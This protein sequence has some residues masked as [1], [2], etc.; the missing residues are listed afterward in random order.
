MLGSERITFYDFRLFHQLLGIRHLASVEGSNSVEFQTRCE[1]NKPYHDLTLFLGLSTDYLKSANSDLNHLIWLDYDFGYGGICHNDLATILPRFKA[2]TIVIITIDFERPDRRSAEILDELAEELPS[3]I[4]HT[5]TANDMAAA[6]WRNTII[7]LIEKSIALGL[8]GRSGSSGVTFLRLFSFEYRDT[9]TMYTFGGM[10][11]DPTIRKRIVRVARNWPFYCRDKLR[12]V[13]HIPHL[14]M[15]RKE[16]NYLDRLAL[17][18]TPYA[19]EIGVSVSD[20]QLYK[21]YYRYLPI[22]SEV[23]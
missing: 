7:Q 16:R 17:S 18:S 9:Q 11:V 1:F 8:Y 14:I 22:Y 13:K 19:G 15:T 21:E 4:L 5:V 23:L 12:N 2:G 6:N 20:F 3:D 10:I